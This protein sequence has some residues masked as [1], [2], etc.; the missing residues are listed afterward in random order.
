MRRA[1]RAAVIFT[2]RTPRTFVYRN[3]NT[4][5]S[6]RP[7]SK[8]VVIYSSCF[9]NLENT[10][11]YG[12]RPESEKIHKTEEEWKKI[13]TP[14]QYKICRQGGTERAGSGMHLHNDQTGR[15]VCVCCK[16]KLFESNTK[17]NSG[18]GWPSFFEP[19]SGDA[20]EEIQDDSHGMTRTEVRCSKC[21]S[22]LGH[23]FDDG[24]KPTE[25]RYCINSECLEFVQEKSK[26]WGG[27]L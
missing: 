23:V 18:T 20:V 17:Y 21:G 2:R 22:H 1:T 27:F 3:Q 24:P 10:R 26:R 13:L 4:L 15:Y 9:S 8:S 14:E 7:T 19:A 11:L 6:Y 12:S 25:K 16:E 5:N